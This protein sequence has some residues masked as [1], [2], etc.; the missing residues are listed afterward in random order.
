MAATTTETAKKHAAGICQGTRLHVNISSYEGRTSPKPTSNESQTK[1]ANIGDFG[2]TPHAISNSLC[3]LR[4]WNRLVYPRW[5][6]HYQN[7]V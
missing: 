4:L 2:C 1:I 6:P 3:L 7:S 5:K